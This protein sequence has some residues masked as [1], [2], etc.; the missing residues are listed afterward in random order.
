M[1][2]FGDSFGGRLHFSKLLRLIFP[3]DASFTTLNLEAREPSK[4]LTLSPK[5][6]GRLKC[7][8]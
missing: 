6:D 5:I 2:G 7:V 4:W 1:R 3:F 8:H